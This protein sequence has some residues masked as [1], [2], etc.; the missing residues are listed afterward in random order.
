MSVFGDIERADTFDADPTIAPEQV[1]YR[2]HALRVIVQFLAGRFLERWSQL[3]DDERDDALAVGAAVAR[4]VHEREP[5]NPAVLAEMVHDFRVSREGGRT[6]DDL[7]GDERQI[8]IDLL[9]LV[10]DWLE[11]EGPR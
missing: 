8:A 3:G 5:D 9:D 1:A 2:L 11:K 7:A 6:W 10:L 4:Y